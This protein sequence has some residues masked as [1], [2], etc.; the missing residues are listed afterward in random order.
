MDSLDNKVAKIPSFVISEPLDS[1]PSITRGI[2]R[3]SS[4]ET[5]D[6]RFFS[7]GSDATTEGLSEDFFL[8]R[9]SD[10]SSIYSDDSLSN[11]SL[12]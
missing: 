4:S 8:R 2:G 3:K 11:D 12:R 7:R 10:K 1:G 6:S 5:D 9:N